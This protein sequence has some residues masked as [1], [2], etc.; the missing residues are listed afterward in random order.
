MHFNTPSHRT[1]CEL[2]FL[3]FDAFTHNE[4]M[5]LKDT[6]QQANKTAE[7]RFFFV[8]THRLILPHSLSH[9]KFHKNMQFRI[10]MQNANSYSYITPAQRTALLI[11]NNSD[12]TNFPAIARCAL[13]TTLRLSTGQRSE[14]VKRRGR[15]DRCP[16]DNAGNVEGNSASS[17]AN[18]SSAGRE[19]SNHGVR[20]ETRFRYT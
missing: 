15:R 9:A 17:G 2:T 7:R 10:D 5:E 3:F 16:A 8:P 6:D 4:A 20:P 12:A 1:Q 14:T 19:P 11:L 18:M 13:T